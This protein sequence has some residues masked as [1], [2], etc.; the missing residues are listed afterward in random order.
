MCSPDLIMAS[1]CG[2]ILCVGIVC[3]DI[4]NHLSHYPKEDE[5]IRAS[6]QTRQSG[7]NASN[8]AKVLS[9]L[10][11]KC[12]LLSTIGVGMEAE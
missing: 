12:E 9:L 11:R 10:G 3:L 2:E 6:H 4:V 1:G 5:D 8:T 7:G